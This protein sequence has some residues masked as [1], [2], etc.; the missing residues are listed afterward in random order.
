MLRT[1]HAFLSYLEQLYANR[2]RT[3]DIVIKSF[4]KGKRILTQNESSS[5]IMLI[6]DG[7]TKCYFAEENEK[8][9]II[10]FLGKGEIIGEI[11]FIK[12]INCLCS[13]EAITDVTVYA[14]SISYFR[15]LIKTDLI[16]N[17]LLLDVF[18]E[19]IVN[20]STRASYQ[21]LYTTEHTLAKLLEL[22]SKQEI[23]ISK[24]DQA[25]YLGV[26]IRSLNRALKA[27]NKT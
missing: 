12:N 17:N 19:R 21:Q 7:I 16:L 26:T 23:E 20:T 11:E 6:N 25:A 15:S 1:N 10:E 8:E 4:S 22:Q 13:I 3:D 24:E 18:A 27:L 9:Y 14:I 5:T 2:R